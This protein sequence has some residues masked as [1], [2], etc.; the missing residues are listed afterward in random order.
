MSWA[1][2]RY[3][4]FVNGGSFTPADA[5]AIQDQY[6]RANGIGAD[7][8]AKA[9]V[10]DILGLTTT[11]SGHGGAAVRRGITEIAGSQNVTGTSYALLATPDRVQNVVVPSNGLL[12]VAYWATMTLDGVAAN[13]ETRAAIFIGAN[14]L[15][16]MSAGAAPVVDESTH[17]ADFNKDIIVY[18][19]DQGMQASSSG[20][21]GGTS[22]IGTGLTV[23]SSTAGD[24]LDFVVIKVDPGTYDIS[25]QFMN[26]VG[27]RTT[28]V[29]NRHL[30]VVTKAFA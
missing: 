19:S 14:Q 26:T 21:A 20:A 7:D 13:Y 15:K 2:A 18:T 30:Y 9:T 22:E 10:T 11:A 24:G 17:P 6:V 4:T 1:T 29:K 5:N 23:T 12:Y 3:K 28:G 8:L 25:V 27:A 16:T